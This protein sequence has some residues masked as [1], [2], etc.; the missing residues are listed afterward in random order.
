M[1]LKKDFTTNGRVHT[2]SYFAP[3]TYLPNA[4]TREILSDFSRKVKD[5][6][7]GTSIKYNPNKSIRGECTNIGDYWGLLN[8]MR[9]QLEMHDCPELMRIDFCVDCNTSNPDGY[10]FWRKLG[11]WAIACFVVKKRVKQRNEGRTV[12]IRT[13]E[14]ESTRAAT[15]GY[16]LVCYNKALQKKAEGIG[17]RFEIRHR[18]RDC[19]YE[20]EALHKMRDLLR[21]LPRYA[22]QA[23]EMQNAKLITLWRATAPKGGTARQ[24]NEFITAY[25]HDIY[26]VEQLQKLYEAIGYPKEQAYKAR[27]NYCQ[28]YRQNFL[29]VTTEELSAFCEMA[30]LYIDRFM[31][32]SSAEEKAA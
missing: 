30:A 15:D 2:A 25:E 18:V 31:N 12:S 22:D 13:G 23:A 26:T 27:R 5:G 7:V 19:S 21:Q 20:Q 24:V 29:P 16:E 32:E 10:H 3:G 8:A 4:Y 6:C 11:E 1:D 14:H 28:R 9:V 17:Y